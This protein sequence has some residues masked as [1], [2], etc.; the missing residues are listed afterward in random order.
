MFDKRS[1]NASRL[2]HMSSPWSTLFGWSMA[3]I[4]VPVLIG[5]GVGVMSM[6]PPEFQIA[7]GCFTVA[8]AVL[9]VK[10]GEWLVLGGLARSQRDVLALLLFASIGTAWVEAWFWVGSRQAIWIERSVAPAT[11][12]DRTDSSPLAYEPLT[13][14]E[15]AAVL[16]ELKKLPKASISIFYEHYG[17]D[18]A[19]SLDRLYGPAGLGWDVKFDTTTMGIDDG[20]TLY[21]DNET[22][23]AITDAIR[24]GTKGRLRPKILA[25]NQFFFGRSTDY[26]N[27]LV[28]GRIDVAI[29]NRP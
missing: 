13:A 28:M 8:T 22:T 27:D 24:I 14:E 17:L 11:K 9:V 10:I 21:P 29:G 15:M 4:V 25:W 7:R 23:H 6:S 5:V 2:R 12:T 18:L 3:A 16:G 26:P 19:N 20:I 1:P